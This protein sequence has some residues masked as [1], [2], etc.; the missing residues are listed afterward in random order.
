[1]MESN[2]RNRGGGSSKYTGH[3]VLV[4]SLR[5]VMTLFNAALLTKDNPAS[6]CTGREQSR[7]RSSS[8]KG[9]ARM[10]HR[11]DELLNAVV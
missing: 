10:V 1:M 2:H 7:G 3:A 5:E 9:N 4:R 8:D 11:D 6:S